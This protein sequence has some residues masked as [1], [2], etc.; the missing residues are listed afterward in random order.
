MLSKDSS[1]TIDLTSWDVATL[2]TN[3]A[4]AWSQDQLTSW[5]IV[6]RPETA[7]IAEARIAEAEKA[8]V[9]RLSLLMDLRGST[10][11]S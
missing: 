5:T 4:Y 11:T 10:V 3:M 7:E 6:R 9:L 1:E 2:S 8:I